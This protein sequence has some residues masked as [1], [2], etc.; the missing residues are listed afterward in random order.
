[1]RFLLQ[2]PLHEVEP[3]STSHSDCGNKKNCE[4]C[5]FQGMLHKATIRVTCVA[6]K[7]RDKLQEK[8]PSVTAAL[9]LRVKWWFFLLWSVN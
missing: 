3:T 5:L 7:L 6:T 1:M 4:T 2:P 8:L 9:G